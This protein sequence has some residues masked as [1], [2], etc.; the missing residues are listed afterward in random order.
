MH[1][2]FTGQHSLSTF[3]DARSA[4]AAFESGVRVGPQAFCRT[5]DPCGQLDKLG[6]DH[7]RPLHRSDV[8]VS[9]FGD[10]FNG[11]FE[12]RNGGLLISDRHFMH[13]DDHIRISDT[14]LLHRKSP[15]EENLEANVSLA[16]TPS[17]EL[18][19]AHE[20][21]E[22]NHSVAHS[23]PRL[24]VALYHFSFSR[25]YHGG[26]LANISQMAPPAQHVHSSAVST[27]ISMFFATNDS[28]R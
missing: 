15:G 27:H 22:D 7:D 1:I 4:G 20:S 9:F 12:K 6:Y 14:H 17:D 23:L 2:L 3:G 28:S 24:L 19:E 16:A 5:D 10:R 11:V 21:H 8:V 25:S 18:P 26:R 13:R